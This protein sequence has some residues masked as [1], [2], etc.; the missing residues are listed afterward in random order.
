MQW[1]KG[2][3]KSH[4]LRKGLSF[5]FSKTKRLVEMTSK[6]LSSFKQN[7]WKLYFIV[8]REKGLPQ[9]M[10]P[11]SSCSVKGGWAGPGN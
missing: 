6:I 3:A 11:A 5:L 8:E 2:K 10:V 1:V 4:P 9:A 7:Q